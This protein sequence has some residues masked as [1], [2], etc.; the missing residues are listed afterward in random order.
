M[1]R[2]NNCSDRYN[3][4][5]IRLCDDADEPVKTI[6]PTM[7]IFVLCWIHHSIFLSLRRQYPLLSH[8]AT[9]RNGQYCSSSGQDMLIL[10][11]LIRWSP[12]T[13]WY[14]K[15][16]NLALEGVIEVAFH[17]LDT[18]VMRFRHHPLVGIGIFSLAIKSQT[19]NRCR[20]VT[21][22]TVVQQLILKWNKY[23]VY[24]YISKM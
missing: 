18:D 22:F 23:T 11:N 1:C 17:I 10:E 14:R 3:L 12:A 13:E 20:A 4:H 9:H 15:R 16:R 19:L 21:W 2:S 24:E 5:L 6:S 7:R 8:L